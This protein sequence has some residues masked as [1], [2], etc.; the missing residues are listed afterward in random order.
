MSQKLYGTA[1]VTPGGGCGSGQLVVLQ[2]LLQMFLKEQK[3]GG[4]LD[5][6]WG[7]TGLF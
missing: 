2:Q 3:N 6:V 4:K 7:A 1:P 5:L